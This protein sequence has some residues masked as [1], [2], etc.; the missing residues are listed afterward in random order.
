MPPPPSSRTAWCSLPNLLTRRSTPAVALAP[1]AESCTTVA[2]Y[3]VAPLQEVEV[4]VLDDLAAYA[5][6]QGWVVPA[7][8]AVA[9]SGPL[10]QDLDLRPGWERVRAVAT[11]SLITG[12]LVPS[13][14]HIAYRWADWNRERA[15]LL[16]QG[17]FVVASDPTELSVGPEPE[18][19]GA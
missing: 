17:L 8:C 5:Q 3:A 12:V 15:W 11:G 13:F 19:L 9:D 6:D 2:L 7:G 14:S 1:A 4:L 16:Q 10:D 18:E